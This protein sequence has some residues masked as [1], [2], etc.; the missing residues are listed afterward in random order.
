MLRFLH[1]RRPGAAAAPFADPIAA[2]GVMYAVGDIHGRHDL[3]L[4]LLDRILDDATAFDAPPALVFLGDY[5][6]RGEGASETVELLTAVAGWSEAE[7]VFLMGNHEQ[8]L[9]RFLRE[10]ET[11][12]H[13]L[14]F[15]GLQTLM[16][17]GVGS[18]ANLHREGGAR[19]VRAELTEALG[20]HLGF[21]EGLR[22]SHRAG[23]LFFAH[24]GA[25]PALPV[26]EQDVA[27]LLWGCRAFLRTDR[28]DGIWVV[29][30]HT[31]VEHPVA[32]RGRISVDTGAYFSGRLTAA[33]ITGGKVTFIQA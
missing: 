17:Y 21:I 13:W 30:G 5:I 18:A 23:N 1:K 24:A 7:T 19:R 11:G 33:R 25:D 2:D 6:D 31:V 22:L 27:T 16:S 32:A 3:L 28:D 14:R 12:A 8:M 29:H 15:G 10:P 9:L 26:E 20:P 4:R